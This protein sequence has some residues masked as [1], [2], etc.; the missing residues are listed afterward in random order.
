MKRKQASKK[1][2]EGFKKTPNDILCAQSL[3]LSSLH[4]CFLLGQ[5]GT[6]TETHSQSVCRGR[7]LG[8]LSPNWGVSIPP[9]R[10]Q[11]T[12]RRM[13]EEWRSQS[14]WKTPRKKSPGLHQVLCIYIMASSLVFLWDSVLWM[15]KQVIS[16]SCPLGLFSFCLFVLYNSNLMGFCLILFYYY[17]YP[18]E[19]S[20][21]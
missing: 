2:K 20:V 14:G 11:G 17:Y 19:A 6:D 1:E 5:M 15:C 16:R 10:A 18:L 8:T 12:H 7:D 4:R 9:L 21:H 3:L 13:R